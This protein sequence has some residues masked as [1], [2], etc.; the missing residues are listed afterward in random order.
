[1]NAKDLRTNVR[2]EVCW[3]RLPRL[4]QS[5]GSKHVASL[6][7]DRGGG[8]YSRKADSRVIGEIRLLK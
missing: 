8:G 1:M 2:S 7:H 3:T 5:A 6:P 4:P